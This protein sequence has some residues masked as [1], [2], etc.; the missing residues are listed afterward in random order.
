MPI[1]V[2]SLQEGNNNARAT[3]KCYLE[4]HSSSWRYLLILALTACCALWVPICFLFSV[5]YSHTFP[6]PCFIDKRTSEWWDV[7]LFSHF[8]IQEEALHSQVNNEQDICGHRMHWCL[9]E[10]LYTSVRLFQCSLEVCLLPLSDL[11]QR[12]KHIHKITLASM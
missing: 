5:F 3:Q 4:L 2:L 1:M 6:F 11:D 7:F 8:M 10:C 9:K 12:L